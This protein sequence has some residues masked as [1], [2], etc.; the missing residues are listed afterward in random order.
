[1]LKTSKPSSHSSKSRPAKTLPPISG[2]MATIED[3][4]TVHVADNVFAEPFGWLRSVAAKWFEADP[5]NPIAGEVL[6]RI[7]SV[8]AKF[9]SLAALAPNAELRK[10]A[11][12]IVALAEGAMA[13]QA[14][15]TVMTPEMVVDFKHK[16]Y[17]EK[18]KESGK[19][20]RSNR[21][22]VPHATTLAKAIRADH[23]DYSQDKVVDEISS[24]W[25]ADGVKAPGQQTLKSHISEPEKSG[26]LPRRKVRQRTVRVAKGTVRTAT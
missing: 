25:K 1:M 14:E 19:V 10:L 8:V 17:S 20:R 6:A 13:L 7:D 9:D 21:S 23:P 3:D 22:W 24:R 5:K 16:L 18:G 26:V 2:A 15:R 4:D 11:L 12:D